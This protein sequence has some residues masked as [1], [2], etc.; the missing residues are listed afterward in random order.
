MK[1][2]SLSLS[3][4]IWHPVLCLFFLPDAV[5]VDVDENKAEVEAVAQGW[6]K[7]DDGYYFAS[8]FL[9]LLLLMMIAELSTLRKQ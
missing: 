2:Q 9:I 6:D 1:E 3:I 8:S 7:N 5:D 4:T